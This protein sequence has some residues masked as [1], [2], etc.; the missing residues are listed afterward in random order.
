MSTSS[1]L[2]AMYLP[3]RL[4]VA[5]SSQTYDFSTAYPH[6]GT[7][8][9]L[10][11]DVQVRRTEGREMIIAEEFGQEI[12]DELYLA[13]SWSMAFALRGMD[14]DALSAI[15]P[16]ATTGSVSKQ[17]GVVYPGATIAPGTL[18]ASTAI[19][20]LFTPND[21]TNH[22]AVYFPNAI[23]EVSEALAVDFARSAELMMA[24]AFRAIRDG[25]SAGRMCQVLLL[26]DLTL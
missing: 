7:A 3:G 12:I 25:S 1:A 6:G 20:M 9:G 2:Q 24:C 18:K 15:F 17:K 4:S 22:H 19:K 26:E 11:R 14:Q 10:V 13:E 23:P 5:L 8:L 16:N 21:T